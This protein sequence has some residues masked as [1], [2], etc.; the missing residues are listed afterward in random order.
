MQIRFEAPPILLSELL[1]AAPAHAPALHISPLLSCGQGVRWAVV[2][3]PGGDTLIASRR[4]DSV[5]VDSYHVLDAGLRHRF[6]DLAMEHFG[7]MVVHASARWHE[8]VL[9]RHKQTYVLVYLSDE[10]HDAVILLKLVLPPYEGVGTVFVPRALHKVMLVM[11]TGID[12]VCG[13][14]GELCA[15]YHNGRELVADATRTVDDADFLVCW[16]ELTDAVPSRARVRLTDPS[17]LL[18]LSLANSSGVGC[19]STSEPGPVPPLQSFC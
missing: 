19:N 18:V 7:L 4:Y 9:V 6:P 16:Q 14:N 12:L 5:D 13:P 8:P 17:P 1:E 11:Q 15:C 3:V 2:H 10:Y